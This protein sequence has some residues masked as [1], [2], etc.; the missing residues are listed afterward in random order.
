[1]VNWFY[2]GCPDEEHDPVTTDYVQMLI[3]T[4]QPRRA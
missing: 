3:N 4:A 2:A 1:V